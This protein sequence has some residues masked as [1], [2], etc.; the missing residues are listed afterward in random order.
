MDRLQLTVRHS[1]LGT[2]VN[3]LDTASWLL[4]SGWGVATPDP[5]K[6]LRWLAERA[7]FI[8]HPEEEVVQESVESIDYDIG[9][10]VISNP[11]LAHL[12][13]AYLPITV[14]TTVNVT[15]V[16]SPTEFYVQVVSHQ[17]SYA[18]LQ[19][20]LDRLGDAMDEQVGG[21]N[22]RIGDIVIAGE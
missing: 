6:R 9:Q 20:E 11:K 14:F 19:H 8:T 7:G 3:H 2:W 17:K 10:K 12:A 1:V 18:S 4:D 22:S 15:E 21:C 5:V 16:I 13:Q